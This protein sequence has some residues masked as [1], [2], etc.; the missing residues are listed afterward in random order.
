MKAYFYAVLAVVIFLTGCDFLGLSPKKKTAV[1]PVAQEVASAPSAVETSA[2]P[3]DQGPLSA[4]T[5][6]RVGSWTLTT[7]EFNERIKLL[8]QGMPDFNEN[9]PNAKQMVLDELIRQQLMVQDAQSSDIANSKEIKDAVED[10]RKTLLVQELANRLTKDVSATEADAQKY[11]DE[12][13]DLFVEP[14]TWKVREIVVADEAAAKNI[15]VQILQGADFAETAKAQSK[16]KTADKGGELKEFT[17]APFAAM[18]SAITNVDVGGTSA[19]FK[20]PE[21]YYIVKVEGKK[22]GIAKP[23]A[24]VKAE[25]I[26]GLTMRKQQEVILEH[27]NKL[28]EKIKIDIN[29]DLLGSGATAK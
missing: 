21:G 6:A 8:K 22:G 4:D 10:F 15:L 11:Y 3:V 28:A 25:L 16:G 29:K 18:Q 5:L 27:L 20:G 9:E 14:I 17:K 7:D 13:K 19:T 1:K 12:N 26:S 23:F 2:A 24:E